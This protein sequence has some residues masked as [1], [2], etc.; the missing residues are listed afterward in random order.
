MAGLFL[1]AP[2]I[3]SA[4]TAGKV[5]LARSAQRTTH[6]AA[7]SSGANLTY[8]GARIQITNTNYLILWEPSKL[9]D[10]SPAVV[11]AQYNALMQR[12]FNDVGG[13][14]LYNNNTQY[15]ELVNGKKRFM[16]NVSTL[17]GVFVDTTPY[18]KNQC[19]DT[20]TGTNCVTDQNIVDEA[21]KVRTALGWKATTKNTFY[22]LTAKGEGSCATN[23]RIGCSFAGWCG[24]HNFVG[25]MIYANIPYANSFPVCTTLH[26]FPNDADADV[27]LSLLSHEQ[28]EAA[29]DG[30]Y[31]D[32]WNSRSDA[33]GGEIADLCA[34]NYGALDED[35]GL[36]NQ[37]WNN[38]YYV[39][40]MEWSNKKSGCVQDG[41]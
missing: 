32:G 4:G 1:G 5:A 12:Y 40:Q 17:G 33:G 13:S 22:V 8:G 18:P 19:T 11:S 34:Y 38:H 2:A 16:K 7:P 35:G 27:T 36:A 9:Q 37:K 21:N 24:Y 31:P 3:A 20:R 25:K 30:Y 41:P 10:G 29:T 26:Q 39:L 28:I 6:P 14:G 15:Y 23:L